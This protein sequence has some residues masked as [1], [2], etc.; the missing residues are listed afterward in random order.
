MRLKVHTHVRGV[1]MCSLISVRVCTCVVCIAVPIV[2]WRS[3]RCAAVRRPLSSSLLALWQASRQ[4]PEMQDSVLGKE[5]L[6]PVPHAPPPIPHPHPPLPHLHHT[7]SATPN[8][9]LNVPTMPWEKRQTSLLT[10]QAVSITHMFFISAQS[11]LSL[12]AWP[13]P[14]TNP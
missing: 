7:P 9:L 12:L 8:P 1:C 10:A 5:M 2:R 14:H 3:V 6:D 13:C 11:T 4:L